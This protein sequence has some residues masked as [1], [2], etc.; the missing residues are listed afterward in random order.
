MRG[1]VALSLLAVACAGA[2]WLYLSPDALNKAQQLIG[3]KQVAATDK[4]AADKPAGGKQASGGNGGARSASIVS[5][6]A[7]TADFPIRRYAIGF[8]SSPAVVNI[9]ARVSSQIVSI[10]V[11]DG[12]MVKT[13]DVL[14]SLDDRALKAQLAKDQ[15][16][17]AKDQ[18]LLASSN[19]DLQR[20]KDLVAKQAGTQQT[21]DQAVAAQKAAAATVDA[22]KATIDADNVQ[23][24]FAT[25][26]APIS[27]RLGAVN[28][29]VGDLVTV[30]NGNS[31]TATPLVTITQMDPLQVNFNLPER[32][33]ALLHK[34]LANPQQNAVTLTQNGDPRPIGKGTLDFVDSS[35]DTASGTIATRASIPNADLSLWPGQYVNVVLDAGIMPQMTSVP[36]VAVQPSQKGPFVYVVKPD[37]TVQMRPV[38][39]ALTEGENSA[40]SQGLKSGEKVVTEGQTRL[41]DGAAV[42][43]GKEAAPKVAQATNAGGEAQ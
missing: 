12:Q 25:I 16:T 37:N 35:V 22:D 34:A 38:Q 5:A 42:H 43:E 33:L 3:T 40:I 13:G 30:S 31:S 15:A 17:L 21:Y 24:G 4:P 32:D 28:V 20:A 26:A 14:F 19:S 1:K 18:A 8:V 9:N 11:K 6:T 2:A 41:K 29:A 39:V 10:D 23:L 36:T 27:G 7:T